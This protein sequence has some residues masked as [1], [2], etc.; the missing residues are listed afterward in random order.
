MSVDGGLFSAQI[1]LEYHRQYNWRT[2][3]IPGYMIRAFP[4]EVKVAEKFLS[5]VEKLSKQEQDEIYEVIFFISADEQIKHVK[6]SKEK[7]ENIKKLPEKQ[8]QALNKYLSLG[9]RGQ[10]IISIMAGR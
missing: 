8:L 2:Q 7:E 5:F 4:E 1:A 10:D 3:E 6:P 9:L